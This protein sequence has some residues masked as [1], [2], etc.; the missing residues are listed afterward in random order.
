MSSAEISREKS[1]S[2]Q[3]Q[4]QN[5]PNEIPF[6]CTFGKKIAY[7]LLYLCF[8]YSFGNLPHRGVDVTH[9]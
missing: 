4:S 5:P 2:A 3:S 6:A 7:A 9:H 8:M 1:D